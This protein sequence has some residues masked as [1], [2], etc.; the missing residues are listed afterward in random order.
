MPSSS[1]SNKV[2]VNAHVQYFKDDTPIAN[3]YDAAHSSDHMFENANKVKIDI[4]ISP[5]VGGV[6]KISQSLTVRKGNEE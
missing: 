4:T 5:P 1:P 3:Q 2:S 6:S